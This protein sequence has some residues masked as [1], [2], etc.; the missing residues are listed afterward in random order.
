[1]TDAQS[2]E[3]AE[4]QSRKTEVVLTPMGQ[5]ELTQRWASVET[6]VRAS[7]PADDTTYPVA[8]AALDFA[9]IAAGKTTF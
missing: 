2:A 1:M 8:L 9:Q 6:C 5:G 4:S 7:L 3:H